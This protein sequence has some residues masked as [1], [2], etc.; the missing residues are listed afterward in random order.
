M[1]LCDFHSGCRSLR[2]GTLKQGSF[3]AGLRPW[4]LAVDPARERKPSHMTI[5]LLAARDDRSVSVSNA[6]TGE[7]GRGTWEIYQRAARSQL[8]FMEDS[9]LFACNDCVSG[10]QCATA[11]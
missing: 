1:Y 11:A 6:E 7:W 3:A 5:T 9:R 2:E 10:R 4:V 8:A